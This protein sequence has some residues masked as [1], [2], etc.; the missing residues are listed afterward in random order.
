MAADDSGGRGI[1]WKDF[2][3]VPSENA[4]P[5]LFESQPV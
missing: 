3:K 5:N 4:D 1:G 2:R